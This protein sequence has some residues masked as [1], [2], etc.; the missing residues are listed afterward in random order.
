MPAYARVFFA[1]AILFSNM[2]VLSG[3]AFYEENF[4]FHETDPL[5]ERFDA[6]GMGD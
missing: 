3:E 5:N 2:D 4:V 1:G 6:M